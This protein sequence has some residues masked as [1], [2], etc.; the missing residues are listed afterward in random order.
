MAIS[1]Q[2]GGLAVGSAGTVVFHAPPAREDWPRQIGLVPGQADCFQHREAAALLDQAAADGG[3]AVVCQLFSG[4]GGVGKTQLAA[5]YARTAWEAGEV[6]LLMWINAT[7][8]E[9]I[10]TAY[11][12]AGAQVAGADPSDPEQAIDQLLTWLQTSERRWL[13]VLDDLADPGALH[14]LWPPSQRRGRVLV[15]TRRRD[16]A[17]SGPGRRRIDIGLFTAGESVDYL[18]AKLASAQRADEPAQIAAL[19]EDLGHL[20]LALAQAVTYLID[21]GLSCAEYRTRLADRT[22]ELADVVPERGQLPDGHHDI[23]AATWSLSIERANALRPRGLALPVLELASVLDP[24]GIPTEVLTA[25][26]VLNSL[27]ITRR[28]MVLK[29]R[30]R[31]RVPRVVTEQEAADA[32]SCLHRLSLVDFVPGAHHETVRVHHLVQRA[33]REALMRNVSAD[34]DAGGQE[35]G[36]LMVQINAETAAEALEHV[37]P[38]EERDDTLMAALQANAKAAADHIPV[39][40]AQGVDASHFRLGLRLGAAGHAAEARDHFEQLLA[41]L[42]IGAGRTGRPGRGED[43]EHLFVRHGIAWWQMEA[44]DPAGAATAFQQLL[45]DKVDV[46]GADHP[47]TFATRYGLA[48]ALGESGDPAAAASAFEALLADRLEA[49]TY[50]TRSFSLRR[51]V[52]SAR[53]AEDRQTAVRL[54]ASS[55]ATDRSP[56]ALPQWEPPAPSARY[57][58]AWW[59]GMAGDPAGA[60][61]ALEELLAEQADLLPAFDPLL[62]ATRHAFAHWKAEAGDPRRAILLLAELLTDQTEILGPEHPQTLATRHTLARWKGEV[63]DRVRAVVLLTELLADQTGI[64]GPEHPQTLAT[65]RTLAHWQ[66]RTAGENG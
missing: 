11:A 52:R 18:T 63:G 44:G 43:I 64:L 9:A 3:T 10:T 28:A 66:S 62:L 22:R 32:L 46:L 39:T 27:A 45:A 51:T 40:A 14:G 17:L 19:A 34:D 36:V 50:R 8:R 6:D 33:T 7:S 37:W 21:L 56:G 24:N 2:H 31:K 26:P 59:R 54:E 55:G 35:L 5:H 15:T 23:I 48:R 25:P 49:L 53:R 60:A 30:E 4:T 57:G 38:V 41:G 42:S 29:R 12:R 58:L 1:A 47:S 13:I 61:C 65:R 20:P 16:A